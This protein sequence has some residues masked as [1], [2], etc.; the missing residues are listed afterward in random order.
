MR[1]K[2]KNSL[3]GADSLTFKTFSK[4]ANNSDYSVNENDRM[5][6]KKY[7]KIQYEDG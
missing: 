2:T 7:P 3:M 5:F 6:Y 1:Q 4:Y